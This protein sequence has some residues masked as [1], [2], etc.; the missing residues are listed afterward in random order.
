MGL[1]GGG[2]GGGGDQLSLPTR[3]IQPALTIQV[4]VVSQQQ[5]VL[6]KVP[7]AWLRVWF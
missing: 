2:V 4:A 1:R 6:R 3:D 7:S 5:P